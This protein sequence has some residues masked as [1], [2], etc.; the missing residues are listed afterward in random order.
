VP[1]TPVRVASVF[2]EKSDASD[3]ES[4]DTS[5]LDKTREVNLLFLIL[6]IYQKN[7]KLYF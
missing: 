7:L 4:E 2:V 6:K 3:S 1:L 5:L